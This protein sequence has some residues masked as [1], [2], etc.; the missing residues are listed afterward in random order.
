MTHRN[1]T[2]IKH[3]N[4]SALSLAIFLASGC[5]GPDTRTE[6]KVDSL[7][8]SQTETKAEASVK[9]NAG[10]EQ[11]ASAQDSSS[12]D[13]AQSIE[14]REVNS[15]Q[16]TSLQTKSPQPV[17]AEHMP[18]NMPELMHENT[19]RSALLGV[20]TRAPANILN[21]ASAIS[22]A[23]MPVYHLAYDDSQASE[24]QNERY[25]N[26]AQSS[27]K[28]VKNEPVSTFS[29][30]VDTGSYTNTRRMLN[31]GQLPPA[32][33]VRV[34]EFLN[35][36]D[37]QYSTPE[38]P[39]QAFV[40]DTAIA[41]APWDEARH[42]LRIGLNAYVDKNA[43]DEGSNLVFLLDVSGSMNN[44]NKLPLLKRSLLML[45]KQLSAKDK[46]SIVVYAGASGVVL[47]PT[48]G[49]DQ[50]A[51]AKALNSLRAGGSTNGAAGIEQAYQLAESAFIDGGI[52]RVILATDGDFNVGMTN[53]EAL[54]ELIEQKREKGIALTAL[55]FGQGNYNDYLMEQLADAGDGNY[56]YI[57][58]INEARKVL[59]NQLRSTMQIVAKDV[60]VQ[61]EF[62]PAVVSE[63]RLIGYDNRA[64]ANEDFNNDKVDAGDIGAGHKVTA[65]YEVV[66]HGSES[67]YFEP[68]KYQ[69]RGPRIDT[70]DLKELAQIKLRYKAI[71]NNKS[72]DE[73][74]LLVQTVNEAQISPFE[75][76]DTE[77]K[78]AVAVANFAEQLK[79]SK[80]A[81]NLGL[82]WIAHAANEAKG[83]D[84]FGY[85]HEFV[86]LVKTAQALDLLSN[87]QTSTNAQVLANVDAAEK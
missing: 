74:R 53:H 36:F 17:L 9:T 77:F 78:F 8:K 65:L 59:V 71:H 19:Q 56:A 3:L 1:A 62:N 47:K 63:Y 12:A 2:S 69:A 85:R 81:G 41:N 87:S 54:I 33:A 79:S 86:Q 28:L 34:E 23:S 37:Y 67:P 82:D 29:V 11:Y 76:Q 42:I 83:K 22:A 14:K 20:R 61:V 52:N 68:L 40:I 57:D 39:E 55:G 64:L 66:L 80:Y 7:S 31:Q 45:S 48:A 75:Q 51:I 16:T 15:L 13:K 60:K 46:V 25:Q 38:S 72:D 43:S 73:S 70:A 35:Y 50:Q 10:R 4:L 6:N 84:E 24:V 58:N 49:N 5:A 44:T 30:D 21:D 18:V 27:V 26:I 32:D